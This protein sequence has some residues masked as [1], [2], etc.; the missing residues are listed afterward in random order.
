LPPSLETSRN[1]DEYT[2]TERRRRREADWIARRIRSMLDSGEKLVG[3]KD[4]EK[5]GNPTARAVRQGDIAL[6]F[7]ALTDVAYYEEALRRYGIDYY[8]VG[9]HAFYAQQEVYDLLNLLRALESPADEVALLGVL[10]CPFF[11]LLDETIFWLAQH[12]CGL[13]AGLFAESYPPE[14]DDEQALRA[15]S[16]AETLRELRAVKN[17]V[18]VAELIR[19][20]LDRTAYDAVLLAEFLGERKL[21]NLYKLIE[22]ARSFDASGVFSLAD[23]ITQLSEF[24]V[25]Q[26]KESLAATQAE[27]GDIV[28][29]MSIHQAKG[30]EF[31]VVFLPDLDRRQ[32]SQP[33]AAVFSP[34]LGPLVKDAEIPSG[35]DLFMR[36][37][38]EEDRAEAVRLLYVAATRAADYLI[39]SAGIEEPKSDEEN[40]QDGE[41]KKES[42][43]AAKGEWL[44]LLVR[45]FELAGDKPLEEGDLIKVVSVKP[46]PPAKAKARSVR[47]PLEEIEKKTR[48][49]M[50]AEEGSIPLYLAPIPAEES[51]RRQMSFSRLSGKLHQNITASRDVLVPGLPEARAIDNNLVDDS[52]E[53]S[54]DPRS[55]G[56]LVHAVLAE[57]DFAEPKNFAAL[58][59]RHAAMHVGDD[60]AAIESAREMLERFLTSPRAKEIAAAKRVHRELEF[61]LAWPPG[62]NDRP[63]R[64]FQGFID[65]LYEDAAGGWHI[66][67]FK[68]N[69]VS[70]ENLADV[71]AN[72]EMQ[73]LVYALAAEKILKCPPQ[74]LSLHFLRT[75][76]DFP[77]SWNEQARRRIVEL[78]EQSIKQEC[79]HSE[80]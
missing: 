8:L 25:R 13:R 61:L 51:T 64:Y 75:G 33:P 44:Q 62:A 65:L 56:T 52:S 16:A 45:R 43:F 71:A 20:A 40:A 31:P 69:V 3:D 60:R 41:K 22:Q 67:D 55:L 47:M 63:D 46:E 19:F 79:T 29:L 74:E 5:A 7:R 78:V 54:V 50:E 77:F 32:V 18:T 14:L 28:R 15:K 30:L 1:E 21:A 53:P 6:L 34:Q 27:R 37:E 35:F 17:R 59:E 70:R 23:F 73:M 38:S 10:R 68:T 4:A 11:C 26:P 9:G 24:V 36:A 48:E 58:V 49:M 72:Y 57:I 39:L 12:P 76:W 66:L 2:P 42:K 80:G